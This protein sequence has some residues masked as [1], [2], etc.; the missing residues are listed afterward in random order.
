[1][2]ADTIDGE[3]MLYDSRSTGS[4]TQGRWY[5]TGVLLPTGEVLVVSG[6]D[7]DEVVLPGSGKPILKSEIFDPETETFKQVAE[8]NRPRTYHN[9][10]ALLPD[11]SVLIGGHAPINTAYAYS[12]TLPGFSPNDGRDPS[13]EIYKPAYMFGERPA[14]GKKNKTVSVGERFRIGLKNVDE[15]SAA[16][17][18]KIESAV[19]IRRTNITHLID[20]DQRSVILPIVRHNTNSIVLEMPSQQA[21]VPPGDYMLFVNARDEEGNLVPSASKAITVMG[22]L[23]AMCQ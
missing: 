8:Q 13:F 19:L 4:L 18:A 7:R 1:M 6:A 2:E 20:G 22:E 5:G 17:N 12:V 16:M 3:K 11:G 23:S 9:S 21:V 14:I 10:A 15:V